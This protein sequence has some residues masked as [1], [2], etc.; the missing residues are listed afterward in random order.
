VQPCAQTIAQRDV[1]VAAWC[2]L[3]IAF[4][5]MAF[6]ASIYDRFPGD[7]WLTD[8]FQR[9]NVPALGGYFAFVNFLGDT[10]PRSAMIIALAAT[11]GVARLGWESLLVLFVF[12]SN[13]V[14]SAIKEVVE[15]PR[16]SPELV[17]VS[18]THADFSFPSGHVVGIGALFLVLLFVT[19]T[20][21]P[22]RALRR[23]LQGGSALLIVSAGPARVYIGAH[24]PSDVAGGYLLVLLLVAPMLYLYLRRA[25][26]PLKG[27]E[28]PNGAFA[29]SD[30]Y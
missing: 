28:T 16:P 1:F 13:L 27:R 23:L 29:D 4:A 8:A 30:R 10:W 12:L 7:E 17:E 18:G 14:N 6:L 22:Y 3:A 5:V 15:R 9:V 11:L 26:V 21:V 2:V 19:P 20:V 25:V 24:W